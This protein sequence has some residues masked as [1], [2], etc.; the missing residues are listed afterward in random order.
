M[1]G[2]LV[3]SPM[4]NIDAYNNINDENNEIWIF[5]APSDVRILFLLS[6]TTTTFI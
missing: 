3:K 6:T 5:R 2:E 1:N 4:Q